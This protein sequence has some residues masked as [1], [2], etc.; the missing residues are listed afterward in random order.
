[1]PQDLRQINGPN[2]PINFPSNMSDEEVTGAMRKLYPAKQAASPQPTPSSSSWTDKAY[3]A[4]GKYIPDAAMGPLAFGQKYLVDPFEKAASLGSQAGKELGR[5]MLGEASDP[6]VQKKYGLDKSPTLDAA[7]GVS[8]GVGSVIGG[9][10]TDPR[11]WPFFAS[12]AARPMLQKL[13]S[14]GFAAQMGAGAVEA[15]KDLHENWDK[16]T[17][18]QRWEAGTK[19]GVSAVLSGLA[20]KHGFSDTPIDAKPTVE[21]KSALPKIQVNPP[22]THAETSPEVS[23]APSVEEQTSKVPTTTPPGSQEPV[24]AAPTSE[25]AG[26]SVLPTTD[27]KLAAAFSAGKNDTAYFQQAKEKLGEGAG[28]SDVAREAQ[29]IKIAEQQKLRPNERGSFSLAP[30]SDEERP[31]LNPLPRLAD[32]LDRLASLG[33]RL[34]KSPEEIKARMVTREFGA[35]LR[36]KHLQLEAKLHDMISAH[37]NDGKTEFRAFMDAGEGKQ[38]ASFLKPEDQAVASELHNMFQE[39]WKKVQEITEKDTGIENYLSHLWERPGFAKNTLSSIFAGKRPIAGGGRFLKQRFYEYASDGLDAGLTPVT[40]NPIRMQMA[41]L[42]EVDKFL[43]AHD[44][45]DTYKDAGLVAWHKLGD[46]AP[47]GWQ[48]LNDRLFEPKMMDKGAL[49]QFGTYYAPPDVAKIFNRYVSP[50]LAGNPTYDA[51]RTYGNLLNQVNLGVSG[52]HGVFVTLVSAMTDTSLGLKKLSY[53]DV[54]GIR[55]LLRGTLGTFIGRSATR[56]FA[57]G[58]AIQNEA[59]RPTGDPRLQAYVEDLTKMG[60]TFGQDPFYENRQAAGFFKS[61]KTGHPL[62][63]IESGVQTL[64]KPIMKYYVPRMK[65]GM[66][67]HMMD[68]RMGR[69]LKQGI[70]DQDTVTS[71][72][73]KIWDSVDNRAGQLVYDN[74]FWNKVAKDLSFLTVRAVGWDYGSGREYLGA[75]KDT[76]NQT[77]NLLRG[78]KPEMTDRMAFTIATPLVVGTLGAAATYLAT[79]HGPQKLE[80]YFYPE[81]GMGGRFSFPSY[82]KDAYSFAHAPG[83]TLVHKTHPM[84]NQAIELYKNSDFY[85]TTIYGP[86]DPMYQKGIDVLK[87]WGK[88]TLPFSGRIAYKRVEGGENPWIAGPE[89][90]F[91][92]QPMPAYVMQTKAEGLAF[93]L[94][95]RTWKAGPM[96]KSDEDRLQHISSLRKQLAAGKLDSAGL[97][98]ELRTGQ[99]RPSDL[100]HLFD[101]RNMSQFEANFHRLEIPDALKVMQLADKNERVQL[102]PL[103]IQ[104]LDKLDQYTPDMQAQY[105]KEIQAYLK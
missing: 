71:E 44:L 91:G 25:K 5:S 12:G 1:M 77:A 55:N 35:A 90:F 36:L 34:D 20:A 63:A 43:A 32:T 97:T 59:I 9:T 45:K 88:S 54:G 94:A 41:A 75:A 53:G 3:A 11:N 95:K 26:E 65:L 27:E 14:R 83:E 61:I 60:A 72:L 46:K 10:A 74:L 13:I 57:L 104:K 96:N 102:K 18:Q 37:D 39:R 76:I 98:S 93:E 47:E 4:V 50:G 52:Y 8:G 29:N 87:W 81:D 28:F 66:A 105:T 103:L 21:E 22:S 100:D 16:L 30:I 48:K 62:K 40:F 86:G 17:P 70:F 64:A 24:Q 89:S 23:K 68:E 99:I 6:N 85:N 19:T 42:F 69:L 2:G 73:S 67:A 31:N 80:D 38:G 92:M 82:M 58:K 51:I 15:A 79:G 84:L 33:G 7:L 56:D 101:T 78:K 49:K